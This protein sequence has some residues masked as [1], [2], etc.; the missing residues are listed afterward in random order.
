[1]TANH[2]R[3]VRAT[4]GAD[5]GPASAQRLSASGPEATIDDNRPSKREPVLV[6]KPEGRMPTYLPRLRERG[7]SRIRE[8]S[9][10]PVWQKKGPL[11]YPTMHVPTVPYRPTLAYLGRWILY[12]LAGA[13]AASSSSAERGIARAVPV[14]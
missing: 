4:R 3:D 6:L 1:M 9:A 8:D 2:G 5:A 10:G 11:E 7:S 14:A 12:C 13:R